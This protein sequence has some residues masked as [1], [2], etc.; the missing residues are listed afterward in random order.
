MTE[1]TVRNPAGEW[2]FDGLAGPTHN[3]A[4]LAPGNLA[5]ARNSGQISN[6]RQAALQCLDKMRFVR[7]LG[8]PQSFLPPHYRP[9][10]SVLKQIGFDY[11]I[12]DMLDYAYRQAPHLLASAYSSSY[13]WAANAATVLPSA[14]ST[15][16]KLHLIPANLMSNLHRSIEAGFTTRLL[17]SIFH[18]DA[19]K[20]HEPLPMT[21]KWADEGAANHMRL[22][23]GS[24]TTQSLNIF[25]Y[26]VD[27]IM[28]KSP[29]RYPARQHREASESIARLGR[30][31]EGCSFF[32]QQHP[33]A[34]DAGVFH[35][36]V[37]AMNTGGLI[38]VHEKGYLEQ[39]AFINMLKKVAGEGFDCIEIGE[40]EL[41]LKD[42]VQSYLFN[43][44][45][46][47]LPDN[48]MVIVAPSECAE[49]KPAKMALEALSG[50]NGPIDAI[51]YLDV[52]ESMKNGGGPACLRLRVVMTEKEAASI[53]PGVILTDAKYDA[54]VAWVN[55]HYRDRLSLEDLRDPAFIPELN[56]CYEDLERIVGMPG[57]YTE[58]M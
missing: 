10:V 58:F 25:I 49:I 26:G 56:A 15:D 19:F 52:R 22:S 29:S 13:M 12:N 47:E 36:D 42:A 28:E 35:N 30:V 9:I 20:I 16:G 3:Y 34:I 24:Y 18:N 57:L 4:G 45:L 14:D 48:K 17:R 11:G 40:K 21:N 44:Q 43:S 1:P 5:S 31:K 37:I 27:G 54:L 33:E 46:L 51:H 39:G 8:M 2:Q 6:P 50:G 32:V 53:H 38:V 23:M 41:S 7:A 55:K